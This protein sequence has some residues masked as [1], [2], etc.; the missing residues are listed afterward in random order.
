[1]GGGGK[2]SS[3]FK[4]I[5]YRILKE[6][7]KPLHSKEIT[8]IAL[9]REWLITAGKTPEATMNSLLIVDINKK[10]EKSR[11]I[12]VGPSTFGLNKKVAVPEKEV[13]E[14][15]ERVYKISKGISPRQKGG[16][17]EAR[18]A[19]LITLYGDTTLA[20]YKPISDDEGIDLIVKEKGSQ[21]TMYI[22]VKSRFGDKPDKVFTATTKTSS[23]TDNYQMAIVFCFFDTEQGDLWDYL[24]FVPAPDFLKKANRLQNNT[25][26]GFVAGRRRNEDNKWDEYLIDKRDLANKIIEQ[27]GR[28]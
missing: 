14:E 9:E 6:A 15:P 22:Q 13:Y 5:A 23:I 4:D 24:W 26:L 12:K 2:M 17:A 18:I 1:M 28:Y 7:G 21:K 8:K 11:F 3:G 10:K 19:E 25:N 16:I 20:C 27:M